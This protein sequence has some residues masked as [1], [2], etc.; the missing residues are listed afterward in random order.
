MNKFKYITQGF[1]HAAG[2]LV[3]V[4]AL[5]WGIFN[6]ER[7]FEGEPEFIVPLVML[8]L[9][10]VSATI[11]GLLVLGKPAHLYISGFKKEAVVLLV[12]T[13]CWIVVFVAILLTCWL[14]R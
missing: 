8:L 14:V 5:V 7:F 1:A 9:F 12:S 13:I 2:V 11:T 4:G 3:Y 10:I 6:A